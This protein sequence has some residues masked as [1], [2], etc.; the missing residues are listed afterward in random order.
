MVKRPFTVRALTVIPLAKFAFV[1]ITP[2]LVYQMNH[3]S[4]PRLTLTAFPFDDYFVL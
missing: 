3:C 1:I 4:V 2:T